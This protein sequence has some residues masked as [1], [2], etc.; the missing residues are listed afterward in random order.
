MM[1]V[2]VDGNGLLADQVSWMVSGS[3]AIW[4]SVCSHKMNSITIVFYLLWTLYKVHTQRT[5]KTKRN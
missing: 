3:V 4:R 2:D 1:I 5:Q